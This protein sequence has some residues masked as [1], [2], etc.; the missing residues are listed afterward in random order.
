MYLVWL[1]SL[2]AARDV[3][4]QVKVMKQD[5]E[6]CAGSA[7]RICALKMKNFQRA[8]HEITSSEVDERM[9]MKV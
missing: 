9:L 4:N 2:H 6:N 3:E 8:V 1:Q 7:G 5:A